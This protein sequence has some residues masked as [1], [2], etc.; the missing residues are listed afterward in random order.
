[1]EKVLYTP[2]ELAREI[3]VGEHKLRKLANTYPSFPK[4]RNG[5][6]LLF[7]KSEVE[8]WLTKQSRQGVRI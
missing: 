1:M 3:P 2:K 8:D 6:R 4:I 7:V 5:N